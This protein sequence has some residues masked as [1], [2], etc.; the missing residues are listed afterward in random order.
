[1]GPIGAAAIMAIRI[2]LDH[3]VQENHIIFVCYI[4]SPQGLAVVS[5]TFPKIKIVVSEVDWQGLNES[6]W[7]MPGFG[8]FGD[9]Y[10]GT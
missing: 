7:I 6:Y 5:S 1:M 2:L 4:A 8:N 3:D 10:F 9:R